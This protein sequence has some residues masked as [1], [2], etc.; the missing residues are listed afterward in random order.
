MYPDSPYPGYTWSMN[1]HMG[2]V[3]S[4][5]LYHTLYAAALHA[6]SADPSADINNYLIANNLLTANVR[7]DSGQPDAWRDYQQILSELGLIF[8]TKR[9]KRITPTPLGLA[10]LD[11][12]IGFSQIMTLQAFRY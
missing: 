10:Y 2:I 9:V 11:G 12:S 5:S 8:S 6:A 3:N 7:T 1:H 4:H